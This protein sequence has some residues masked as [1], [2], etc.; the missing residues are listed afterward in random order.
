MVAPHEDFDDLERRIHAMIAKHALPPDIT[1]VG[2]RFGDRPDG[3]PAMWMEL[4]VAEDHLFSPQEAG[5]WGDLMLTLSDGARP[6]VR[7]R[8]P[9]V[10]FVVDQHTR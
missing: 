4:H 8:I 5:V 1:G 2:V 7:D 10:R 3:E 6:I 9:A